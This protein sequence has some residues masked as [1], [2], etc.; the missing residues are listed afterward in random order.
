MRYATHFLVEF[1][2]FHN[3][4]PESEIS[5]MNMNTEKSD[6]AKISK[7]AVQWALSV[8]SDDFTNFVK[9]IRQETYK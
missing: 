4:Q 9:I 8:F 7:H 5:K 3:L 1:N 6:N 2:V